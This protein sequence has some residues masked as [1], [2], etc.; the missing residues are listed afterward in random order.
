MDSVRGVFETK[1]PALLGRDIHGQAVKCGIGRAGDTAPWLPRV[2]AYKTAQ[3]RRGETK[4]QSV[5]LPLRD[6][7]EPAA[8]LLFV[9]LFVEG[10]R[11]CPTLPILKGKQTF[12]PS[13]PQFQ[14][15]NSN[16]TA[17]NMETGPGY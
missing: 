7:S 16:A 4:A 10:L 14:T 1:V 6:V 11:H 15:Q 13:L 2:G 3:W 5:W 9:P 8:I 17:L 12:G